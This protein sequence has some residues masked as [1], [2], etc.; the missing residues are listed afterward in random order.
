MLLYATCQHPLPTSFVCGSQLPGQGPSSTDMLSVQLLEL[1][2]DAAMLRRPAADDFDEDEMN[3]VAGRQ[4][5][6]NVATQA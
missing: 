5:G 1:K 4:V 2:A 6:V 3:S